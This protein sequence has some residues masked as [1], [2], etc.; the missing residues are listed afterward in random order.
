MTDKITPLGAFIK[1]QKEMTTP[2]FNVV[3][4]FH[5]NKYADL[6]A[7]MGACRDALF[8]NKI[9]IVQNYV[10][11]KVGEEYAWGVKTQL[12]YV[13][14]TC[15]SNNFYP[16]NQALDDQK[17]GSA[18][19]YGRRYSLAMA[20][21]LVAEADD[22][23]QAA[24]T[25]AKTNAKPKPVPVVEKIT[26]ELHEQAMAVVHRLIDETDA[27][28]PKFCKFMGVDKINDITDTTKAIHA[29]NQKAKK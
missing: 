26:P 17:K 7:I 2:V 19:T 12:I 25:P 14:G 8:D 4:P 21:N 27:D 20:C 1:A 16:I 23:G 28:V 3:N 18:T 15:F 24:S 11:E 29:L 13:D 9:S 22:D 6:S 10:Y 5:K